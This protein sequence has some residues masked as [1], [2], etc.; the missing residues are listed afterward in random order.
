L[1]S[2]VSL[3]SDRTKDFDERGLRYLSGEESMLRRN[4]QVLHLGVFKHKR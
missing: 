3:R 1:P 4:L 2:L